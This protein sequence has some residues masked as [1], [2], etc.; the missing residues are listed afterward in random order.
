MNELIF[1]DIDGTLIKGQSQLYLLSYLYRNKVISTYYYLKIF[2]WFALYKI[3]CV[4]N[5]KRIMN[6]AFAFLKGKNQSQID[7]LVDDFFEQELKHHFYDEGKKFIE[8]NM[9][10]SRIIL[11]SN[12]IDIIAK[13]VAQ[14]LKVNEYISTKLETVNGIYTGNIV[15]DIVYGESK[16]KIIKEYF[17]GKLTEVLAL[18]SFYTDHLSDLPL[19]EAVHNPVLVNPSRSIKNYALKRNWNIIYFKS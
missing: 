4:K 9:K 16:Y 8:S 15:G 19:L 6:F 10:N 18:S 11:I 3:N 14:Y 7:Q 17:G 1:F 5:P 13:K 2:T 12:T